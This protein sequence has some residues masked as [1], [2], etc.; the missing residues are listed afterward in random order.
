MSVLQ[1]SSQ[2]LTLK[3]AAIYGENRQHIQRALLIFYMTLAVIT[4]S[5]GFGIYFY[6]H[7]LSFGI[8]TCTIG[9]STALIDIFILLILKRLTLAGHFFCLATVVFFTLSIYLTGGIL[10]PYIPWLVMAPVT[11]S[12]LFERKET[13]IWAAIVFIEII[14]FRL[15]HPISAESSQYTSAQNEII[16]FANA[17]L[18]IYTIVLIISSEKIRSD[19]HR[20]R[21]MISADEEQLESSLTEAMQGRELERQRI[22]R[23]LHDGLNNTLTAVR[24]RHQAVLQKNA[25]TEP[26]IKHFL[27]EMGQLSTRVSRMSEDLSV[28]VLR[29]FG[30]SDG[31][32]Y[33]ISRFE[34]RTSITCETILHQVGHIPEKFH[35]PI[36][37]ILQETL[38][39]VI[40]N[41]A[42][43]QVSLQVLGLKT[44][45][46][47]MIEAEG[48]GFSPEQQASLLNISDRSGLS[49]TGDHLGLLNGEIFFDSAPGKGFSLIIEIPYQ[50]E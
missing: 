36:Y 6:I 34:N 9:I 30:L 12:L 33:L 47:I 25:A 2:Y 1:T 28:H 5:I 31:I 19:L 15:F 32:S 39:I 38:Q 35:L 43:S 40:L 48:P 26:K 27:M 21:R 44:L 18:F 4:F 45:L 49:E 37:R 13:F 10:S 24:L 3:L 23:E 42:I 8:I 50:H 46:R 22:S 17:G 14:A 41:A 20:L 7:Q 11:A 29:D 16:L